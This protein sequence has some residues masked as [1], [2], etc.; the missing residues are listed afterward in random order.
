MKAAHPTGFKNGFADDK[1]APLASGENVGF[2]APSS[3]AGNEFEIIRNLANL[4]GFGLGELLIY[5]TPNNHAETS[6]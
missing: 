4:N 6:S 2:R 5:G 3:S 1:N